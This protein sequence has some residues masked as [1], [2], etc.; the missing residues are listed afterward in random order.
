MWV[1]FVSRNYLDGES[2]HVFQ[3]FELVYSAEDCKKLL[4]GGFQSYLLCLDEDRHD[5]L[6]WPVFHKVEDGFDRIVI[7]NSHGY[8]ASTGG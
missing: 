7:A 3:S 8:F 2:S 4:T 6:C 1:L 5:L